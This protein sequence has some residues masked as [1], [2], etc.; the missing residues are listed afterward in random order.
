M[1]FK[2]QSDSLPLVEAE[3]EVNLAN[4]SDKFEATLFQHQLYNQTTYLRFSCNPNKIQFSHIF[5]SPVYPQQPCFNTNYTTKQLK[6]LFSC[7]PCKQKKF[8]QNM[9][10]HYLTNPSTA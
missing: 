5:S 9:I 4:A 8:S 2:C 1:I 6:R 3:L 7:N 10:S